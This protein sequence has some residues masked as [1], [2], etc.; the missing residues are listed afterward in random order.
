MIKHDYDGQI[1]AFLL[2]LSHTGRKF[3]PKR[4]HLCRLNS[5]VFA[6]YQ[7]GLLKSRILGRPGT[8]LEVGGV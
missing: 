2:R 8:R 1:P 4:R 5:Q 7:D 3:I 6:R